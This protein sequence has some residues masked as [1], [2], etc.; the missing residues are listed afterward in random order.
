MLLGAHDISGN[1]YGLFPL[2]RFVFAEDSFGPDGISRIE[3][4][5]PREINAIM[6]SW[7]GN[8]MP[9]V[10]YFW[11]MDDG[12][13]PVGIELLKKLNYYGE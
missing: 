6:N 7:N 13:R 10:V 3:L 2:R 5:D 8:G 4:G 1:S 12:H 11:H 9:P